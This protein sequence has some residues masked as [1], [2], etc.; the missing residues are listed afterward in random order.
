[1]L[2]P[3]DARTVLLVVSPHPDDETLCCAGLMQRVLRAGA[4]ALISA[5]TDLDNLTR[6]ARQSAEQYEL[7]A[8]AKT[9]KQ[10]HNE[11]LDRDAA[12]TDARITGITQSEAYQQG[13]ELDGLR[14]QTA[15]AR[16]RAATGSPPSAKAAMVF[17]PAA[18]VASDSPAAKCGNA[19]RHPS[20][21]RPAHARSQ[22]S[23]IS[24]N[25]SRQ[26]PKRTSTCIFIA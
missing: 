11:D 25:D 6:T 9:E 13:R 7:I 23:A 15:E 19:S 1:M 22:S 18:R 4:A 20:R 21:S 3:V 12:T 17:C 16:S 2:P 14:Q 10:R 8:A 5:T 26:R 24:G